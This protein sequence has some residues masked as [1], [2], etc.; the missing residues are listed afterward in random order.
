M[1]I[2]LFSPMK[3]GI[4]ISAGYYS[5]HTRHCRIRLFTPV[6]CFLQYVCNSVW[7][8]RTQC[9]DMGKSGTKVDHVAFSNRIDMI[10]LSESAEKGPS[11]FLTHCC[12]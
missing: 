2:H 4:F 5:I 9:R 6:I 8:N 12:M 11:S 7:V 3:K 1:T 10:I